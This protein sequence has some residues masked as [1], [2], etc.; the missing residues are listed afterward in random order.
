MRPPFTARPF[1]RDAI[2]TG[3]TRRSF[4]RLFRTQLA[5]SSGLALAAKVPFLRSLVRGPFAFAQSRPP[6]FEEVPSTKTGIS[7][8]H[9]NGRSPEYYIAET[10]GAGCA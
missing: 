2:R 4:L 1:L 3:F 9:V 6:L 10:T 7:W 5:V 8:R